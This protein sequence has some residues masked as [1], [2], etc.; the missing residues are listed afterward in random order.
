M[1]KT[2][3]FITIFITILVLTGCA[4]SPDPLRGWC[5]HDTLYTVSVAG[6]RYPV[7]VGY[8]KIKGIKHVQAQAKINNRWYW[9]E[10]EFGEVVFTE[11]AT[12]DFKP[13]QYF[14]FEEYLFLVQCWRYRLYNGIEK[15]PAIETSFLPPDFPCRGG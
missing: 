14:T 8:G 3:L 10:L 2:I 5:R 7:R 12:F 11:S 13:D 6:E 1:R 15:F 9:L 4:T